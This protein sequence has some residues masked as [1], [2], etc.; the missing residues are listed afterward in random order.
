MSRNAFAL[1]LCVSPRTLENWEQ[2]E[3]LPNDQAAALILMVYKYP[4]TLE[5]LEKI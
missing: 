5:R 4:D 2:G 3:T 1:K